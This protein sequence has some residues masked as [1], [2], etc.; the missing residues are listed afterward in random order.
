MAVQVSYP[1]VYIDEFAPA[2]PIEGVATNIAAFIGIAQRGPLSSATLVTSLD[3][4]TDTFG[5]SVDGPTPYYLPLAVD[6]FFRNGGTTAFIVRVGTA[7]PATAALK[8][9]GA[10]AVTLAAVTAIADGTAGE[11]GSVRVTD[12]SA[13]ATALTAA[14]AGTTVP[15]HHMQVNVVSLDATRRQ[16]TVAA[17]DSDHFE[18]G[19][20]VVLTNAAGGVKRT[21]T[22]AGVDPGVVQFTTAA[23]PPTSFNGGS[24]TTADP[25]AGTTVLRLDV[26]PAVSL[27]AGAP[28][29][30][31]LLITD[32]TRTEWAVAAAVGADRV[33]LDKPL[34]GH[35]DGAQ[36][37]VATAEFDLRITDP[38]GA[39]R[40]YP[41]LSTSPTH[42][43]WWGSAVTDPYGRVVLD[44]TVFPA[45]DPRPA[46]A[47]TPV[48]GATA[49]DPVASWTKVAA[50][51][52]DHLALL[53]P[54]DEISLVA[55]P[56]CTDITA[57]QSVLA[58]CERLYDR[59]AVLDAAPRID[60]RTVK[61][62]RAALTGTL[63]KGFAALYYPWL[64][65]RDPARNRVV[66]QP[67]SGHVVGIYAQTDAR[68]GVHK[69]PANVGIA[70]AVGLERRLTDADQGFINLDGVN[71]LRILPGRGIPIVWGARTTAG[72]RNWQYVNI[73]RLFLYLEES[74]QEGL[75]PSVFEPNDTA[76]WQKLKRT[77]TEFL[78]R[79]WRDGALFGEKAD[80]AFYVRIDDVLNPPATRKLGR[81]T[82]EIGVQPVYPAE[83]IV[84]R[85][86]I[87][88]GGAEIA[89]S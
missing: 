22:V 8:T 82:V 26:P 36:T 65:V 77:L 38:V 67:P 25:D 9:R 88:D 5:G 33:T 21:L 69:A 45:D 6:G 60:L 4:F 3:A 23:P 68:R 51:I 50:D 54:I 84:V 63:D 37:T 39:A 14:G 64:T 1:G 41:G 75:A 44:T 58:H 70:G 40:S 31:V 24:L 34:A 17:G 78:T 72:D 19:D 28:A 35:F 46:A 20:V 16:A 49:D 2:A 80:E 11:G 87:W 62:Q 12:S 7:I 53:A 74:I 30:S 52:D 32:G 83:F 10:P 73:R 61:A 71:A 43:R 55:V 57:Q 66:P 42:P 15:V 59:F 76:L 89:E 18:A 79:T 13:L 81:L 56:G 29:G 48:T 27:R 47:T 86:G 85:I